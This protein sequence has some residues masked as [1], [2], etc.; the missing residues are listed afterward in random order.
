MPN[1]PEFWDPERN[2]RGRHSP[3]QTATSQKEVHKYTR[4]VFSTVRCW[5]D[6]PDKSVLFLHSSLLAIIFTSTRCSR[7]TSTSTASHSGALKK[8]TVPFGSLHQ[9][10]RQRSLIPV[11]PILCRAHFPMS[12]QSVCK[13]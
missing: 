2:H 12:L 8:M 1:S 13:H 3:C 9:S 5:W 7:V 4:L 10:R 11:P 6:G